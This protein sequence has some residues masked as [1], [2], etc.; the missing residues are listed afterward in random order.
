VFFKGCP[1]SCWWCHN[2]EGE[3]YESELMVWPNRCIQ[4]HACMSACPNSA[5]SLS[6]NLIITER[7][8]CKV[9]GICVAR[10]PANARKIVGRTVSADHVIQEAEKDREFYGETGGLT[11]SGGEPLAQPAFLHAILSRCKDAGIHTTV[12]TCGYTERRT[13]TKM[14]SLVDLFLYDLKIMDSK[15]HKKHTGVP[16]EL[17]IEN[18]RTLDRLDKQII[19]RFPLIP[20]INSSEENIAS[21]CELLTELRNVDSITLLLY[22]RLGIDKARRLG[23]IVRTWAKPSE[24]LLNQST[25]IIRSFDLTVKVE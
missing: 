4:C 5:I 24:K 15:K 18:L 19:V 22:H 21:M 14:S 10:C 6:N 1:L 11:A 12:D 16:N 13:L 23:K 9:C 20:R 3:E 7:D 25:R 17:I 8:K 2:P